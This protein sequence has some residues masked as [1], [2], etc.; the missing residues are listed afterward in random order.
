MT[1]IAFI[2]ALAADWRARA[3][4]VGSDDDMFPDSNAA[5]IAHAQQIC[6]PC[7]V[8]EQCLADAM[9]TEG[10]ATAR[11]RY[12]VRAGLTGGQRRALYDE[13]RRKQPGQQTRAAA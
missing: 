12:G 2:R 10:A 4:C 5:D 9:A 6:A 11:N 13:L 8:R 7:P 3:A 1:R